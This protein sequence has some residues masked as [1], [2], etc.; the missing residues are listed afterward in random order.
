MVPAPKKE[1]AMYCPECRSEYREGFDTCADCKVALV[2]ELP[3]E[4]EEECADLVTVLSA[5][6]EVVVSLATSL[7]ESAGI[8]HL[9][10]GEGVQDVF[11]V[12]HMGGGFNAMIGLLEIQ[13]LPEDVEAAREVLKELLEED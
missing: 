6:D 11:G 10:K 12:G 9:A 7:L 4:P 13:V 1:H 3:P 2:A 8:R 5:Q